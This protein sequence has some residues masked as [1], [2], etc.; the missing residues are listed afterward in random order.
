MRVNLSVAIVAMVNNTAI[1]K[2]NTT[3]TDSCPNLEHNST[4]PTHT[5][6]NGPFPWDERRQGTILGLKTSTTGNTTVTNHYFR[7]VFL[8]LC[9]NTDTWWETG[10]AVWRKVVV[11]NW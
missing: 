10:R 9:S 5:D 2:E 7:H 1:P 8:W 3:V 4:T 6:K 11:W